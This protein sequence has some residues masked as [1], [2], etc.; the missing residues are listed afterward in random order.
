MIR[1]I[2]DI[3]TYIRFDFYG[4]QIL[5]EFFEQAHEL[6][7]TVHMVGIKLINVIWEK[8]RKQQIYDVTIICIAQFKIHSLHRFFF[9]F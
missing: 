9:L 7:F 4:N 8:K 5:K 3:L 6:T 2:L 1:Y